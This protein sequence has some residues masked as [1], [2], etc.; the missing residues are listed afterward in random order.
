MVRP[1]GVSQYEMVVAR[2]VCRVSC[3]QTRRRVSC[4]LH[5]LLDTTMVS[6]HWQHFQ[7]KLLCFPLSCCTHKPL[8]ILIN[9]SIFNSRSK[10]MYIFTFKKRT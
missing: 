7:R 8:N 1:D 3:L 4:Q 6:L 10:I 5:C 2:S 9:L